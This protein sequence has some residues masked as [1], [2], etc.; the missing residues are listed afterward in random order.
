MARLY[1]SKP[2]ETSESGINKGVFFT[3]DA[4]N[5]KHYANLRFE[6]RLSLADVNYRDYA[7]AIEA[8][9]ALQDIVDLASKGQV[10]LPAKKLLNPFKIEQEKAKLE[11]IKTEIK[12]NDN[13]K[14]RKKQLQKFLAQ[15]FV[16]DEPLKG[17]RLHIKDKNFNIKRSGS[18]AQ[19]NKTIDSTV[20]KKENP[21][22]KNARNKSLKSKSTKML[23]SP[24]YLAEL[25]AKATSIKSLKNTAKEYANLGKEK[26][27]EMIALLRK[28][29]NDKFL[30]E[31]VD[32]YDNQFSSIFKKRVETEN[33]LLRLNQSKREDLEKNL[34]DSALYHKEDIK[35][36]KIEHEQLPQIY[37]ECETQVMKENSK[38]LSN[39]ENIFLDYNKLNSD[40]LT[41][42][43]EIEEKQLS[44]KLAQK[45]LIDAK[46][47]PDIISLKRM[48]E[49]MGRSSKRQEKPA[50]MKFKDFKSLCF[51]I[52]LDS[53]KYGL[54]DPFYTRSRKVKVTT[55]PSNKINYLRSPDLFRKGRI[56][57]PSSGKTPIEEK[58]H[59]S[60]VLVNSGAS[61]LLPSS[62]KVKKPTVSLAKTALGRTRVEDWNKES[63]Q[64]TF[65]RILSL[66]ETNSKNKH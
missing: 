17:R 4:F 22:L 38:L 7:V 18:A 64:E 35:E 41:Q 31:K 14:N 8:A 51:E 56:S 5:V 32:Q 10:D 55:I 42:V 28:E 36:S 19:I 37:V 66:I 59:H 16:D 65:F 58:L 29:K 20:S 27:R 9:N 25:K 2:Q 23:R 33:N 44:N 3:T 60:T 47:V 48:I 6:Y 1:P 45:I 53:E 62:Y 30:S 54:K 21:L 34:K 12:K 61:S 24:K 49:L 15:G 46:I 50:V 13:L 57:S 39:V 40:Y 43:H 11:E 26:Q 63:I 52:A